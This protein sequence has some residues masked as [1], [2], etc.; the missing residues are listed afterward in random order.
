MKETLTFAT[1][2]EKIGSEERKRGDESAKK[3][4]RLIR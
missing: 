3:Q 1:P 4:V 2:I